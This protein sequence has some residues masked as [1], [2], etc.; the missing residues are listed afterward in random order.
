MDDD[1]SLNFRCG[2]CL[3]CCVPPVSLSHPFQTFGHAEYVRVETNHFLFSTQFHC[4]TAFYCRFSRV[5]EYILLRG[6]V[7]SSMRSRGDGV[8]TAESRRKNGGFALGER[9]DVKDVTEP[10][11]GPFRH[12]AS[13]DASW[14]DDMSIAAGGKRVDQRHTTSSSNWSRVLALMSES[15]KSLLCQ[16][17]D[18]IILVE[19]TR[20]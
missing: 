2:F 15:L 6:C 18:V 11:Q 4:V 13:D 3:A 19:L 9:S 8:V 1:G 16:S 12:G 5:R 20:S 14:D 7:W 17:I 10:G